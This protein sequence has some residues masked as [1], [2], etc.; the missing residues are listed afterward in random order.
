[1]NL[2]NEEYKSKLDGLS[3]FIIGYILHELRDEIP[4]NRYEALNFVKSSISKFKSPLPEYVTGK[5]YHELTQTKQALAHFESLIQNYPNF[6]EGHNDLAVILAEKKDYARSTDEVMSAIRLKPSLAEAQKNLVRLVSSEHK[7]NDTFWEFWQSS[8]KKK[9]T[10]FLLIG[11]AAAPFIFSFIFVP[12]F[13]TFGHGAQNVDVSENTTATKIT[14]DK[15]GK[16]A[17]EVTT[18]VKRSPS[19]IVEIPNSY[20]IW[21]G[22]I[23]AVLLIPQLKTAKFA[24][25]EIELQTSDTPDT[26]LA[27]D[28]ARNTAVIDT[29]RKELEVSI[30]S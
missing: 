19:D 11:V 7:S 2:L 12:A 6:P 21:V 4:E 10:A 13:E 25:V 14:T 20:L 29:I 22:I 26:T 17:R 24:G 1:V 9:V 28:M 23:I 30:P 3:C 15:D 5:I 16:V 27:L 8:F 18:T